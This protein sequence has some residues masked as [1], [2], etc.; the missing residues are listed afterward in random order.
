VK[1]IFTWLAFGLAFGFESDRPHLLLLDVCYNGNNEMFTSTEQ[2]L[3][4]NIK[5]CTPCIAQYIS[6]YSYINQF[7]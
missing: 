6:N 5:T 1:I 4:K 7:S 2:I 3:S